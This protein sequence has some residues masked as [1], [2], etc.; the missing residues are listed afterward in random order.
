MGAGKYVLTMFNM[1]KLPVYDAY[2]NVRTNIDSGDLSKME[3]LH[4]EIGNIG[5]YVIKDV[6]IRLAPGYYQIDLRCRGGKTTQM[7]H[8]VRKPEGGNPDFS[9]LA[10]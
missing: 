6:G 2:I 10:H 8:F 9:I 5:P 4:Q 3:M 7:L 1:N